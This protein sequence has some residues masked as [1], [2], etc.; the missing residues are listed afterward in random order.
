MDE[1]PETLDGP[2][3]AKRL[4]ISSRTLRSWVVAGCIPAPPPRGHNTRYDRAR[5]VIAHAV[6][7]LRRDGVPLPHIPRFLAKKTDAELREIGGLPAP[8]VPGPPPALP[9]NASAPQPPS[10]DA[11]LVGTVVRPDALAVQDGL[12][13]R[14]EPGTD[15]VPIGAEW[16]RIEL[17]PGLELH[18][19]A[20]ASPF[21]H[22]LAAAIASGRFAK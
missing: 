15:G 8:R 13:P 14:D 11:S 2:S 22:G 5:I 3:L 6:A 16:R 12:A 17:L 18:V 19:R 4:G 10:E 7:S 1:I 21:V 20:D 9:P